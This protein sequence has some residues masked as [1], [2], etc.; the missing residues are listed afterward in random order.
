MEEQPNLKKASLAVEDV[1]PEEPR[2]EIEIHVKYLGE[3]YDI[4]E[5]GVDMSYGFWDA[6]TDIVAG[7]DHDIR[8]AREKRLKLKAS[9]R[10]I[11]DENDTDG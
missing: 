5:D 4:Y 8:E 1:E 11:S 6:L 9:L 7:L 2:A 3:E 10:G